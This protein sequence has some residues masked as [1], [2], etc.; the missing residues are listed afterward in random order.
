MR[1]YFVRH[2]KAEEATPGRPDFERGLTDKGLEDARKVAEH[3]GRAGVRWEL[4]LTSPLLRA[5]Q[6]AAVLAEAGLVGEIEQDYGLAP[7]GALSG[8]LARLLAQRDRGGGDL[9]LVGH[10]PS[11]VDWAEELIWGEAHSQM[12]LKPGGVIGIELPAG[13]TLRGACELF[14]L[15]SPK[16]L[17]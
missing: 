14:L 12:I 16:V 9:A 4:V 13:G 11:L 17:A 5:K 3:L 1:V 8:L 15:V 6:T 10:L 2:G 7:G